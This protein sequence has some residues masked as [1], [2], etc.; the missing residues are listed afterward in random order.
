MGF[1][2][3]DSIAAEFSFTFEWGDLKLCTSGRP[4][5]VTNPVFKLSN[6]PEGTVLLKFKMTDLKVRNYN[7]GGG[8]M[9]YNGETIIDSGAFKYKSP[10]PPNGSHKY[11]WRIRAYDANDDK[12]G[13]AKFV[14]K[15][16]E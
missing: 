6:I 8:K 13:S 4:N 10:C 14:R 16:P 11:E 2:S 9:E 1:P 3:K 5:R 15:Y 7:H 12:I